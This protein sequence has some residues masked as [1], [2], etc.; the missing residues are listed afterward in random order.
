M[1]M[2]NKINQLLRPFHDFMQSLYDPYRKSTTMEPLYKTYAQLLSRMKE[3]RELWIEEAHAYDD[4]LYRALD[5]LLNY[6]LKEEFPHRLPELPALLQGTTVDK[7]G[8][9]LMHEMAK[10][11]PRAILEQRNQ[12]GFPPQF[13]RL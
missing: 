5:S 13:I 2:E 11:W 7:L 1:T 12:P 8:L 10:G 4:D 6:Y 3:P 9:P